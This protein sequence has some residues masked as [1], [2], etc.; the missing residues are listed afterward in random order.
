VVPDPALTL[1]GPDGRPVRIRHAV[2]DDAPALLAFYAE[3]GG[4]T[5]WLTFGAEGP[6]TTEAEQRATIARARGSDSAI[7]LVAEW[8]GRI[9]GALNFATGTRARLRHAGEFGIVIARSCWRVGLG[10]RLLELLLAW[11]RAG[12]VVRKIDLRVRPDN[13][14]AIALYESLGFVTEGR[15]TRNTLADG[16]FHDVLLMG[17]PIDPVEQEAS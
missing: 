11:A 9:V 3:T 14:R 5:P 7:V 12:G 4:E 1:P 8:D 13:A 10:R 2:E 17:L 16:A 15:L 6:G